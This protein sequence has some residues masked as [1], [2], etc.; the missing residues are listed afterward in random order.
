MFQGET[1]L[2]GVTAASL[3]RGA[4]GDAIKGKTTTYDFKQ[5]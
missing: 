5:P 4:I 3:Q 1:S 2:P